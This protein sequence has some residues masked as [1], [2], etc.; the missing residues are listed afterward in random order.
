MCSNSHIEWIGAFIMDF[1][2]A[3]THNL[4]LISGRQ[5]TLLD[6]YK[7]HGGLIETY[8]T[9]TPDIGKDFVN[10]YLIVTD[11][12]NT[13]ES[14]KNIAVS[15]ENGK[16]RMNGYWPT[17]SFSNVYST[18]QTNNSLIPFLQSWITRM[19]TIALMIPVLCII[20]KFFQD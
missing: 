18:L 9:N 8:I 20:A 5:V 19:E 14:L 7:Y 12:S 17:Q 1:T 13:T 3:Y 4:S 10:M 16:Y 11:S 2:N 6:S 15:A